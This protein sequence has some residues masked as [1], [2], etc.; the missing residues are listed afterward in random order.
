MKALVVYVGRKSKVNFDYGLTH[1]IWGFKP[2][3]KPEPEIAAGDWIIFG[4]GFS[5]GSPRTTEAAWFGHSIDELATARVSKP[6]VHEST[7]EW[8]DEK[9]KGVVEYSERLRFDRIQ[10]HTGP[11]HLVDPRL[12]RSVAQ[13]LRLSAISNSG[14]V[15]ELDRAP[16]TEVQRV[17]DHPN[18][19]IVEPPSTP[20]IEQRAAPD[21]LLE[22]E[23]FIRSRGF[24][25]DTAVLKR[26]YAS[27]RAKPFVIL[28][29]NSG[30][31]KSRLARLFAEAIGASTE[32]GRFQMI[33][34]R[35]DWNDSSDLL[36][37]FDLNGDYRPGQLIATLLRANGRRDKP[38]FV[39]LD[40]MNL[41]RVEH[42]FSDF[43]SIIESRRPENG[44]VASDPVLKDEHIRKMR[45]DSLSTD[46]VA[47]VEAMQRSPRSIGLPP[48]LYFV[49]TVNMDETTQPFS[50]KVL[51]R[52]N[53]L[54]FNDIDL[55][56][57]LADDEPGTPVPS[58]DLD[59]EFLSSQF[60]CLN[61]VR[62][63][64]R[65]TA[66]SVASFLEKL[67]SSL[68]LAGFEVG[69]RIRDE[70]IAFTIYAL[71]AGMNQKEAEENIVLQKVLPRVQGSSPRI[72]TALIAL[73]KQLA[74][75]EEFPEKDAADFTD[76]LAKFRGR[77]DISPV[78]RKIAGML[79]IFR[80]EG[81]TSF[82]LA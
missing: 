81:F 46:V 73:M 6:F 47:M 80:E 56:E 35:P 9:H 3:R 37:Y 45:R 15:V 67:N 42:Y 44:A 18:T 27:L 50:R 59:S 13:A 68:S 14:C 28:A 2:N 36:G 20:R 69:Y 34:V 11:I 62:G 64:H 61:D 30:T 49:G 58:L 23:N 79:L 33:P 54:E 76:R 41:A 16:F 66:G 5:G 71:G 25:F 60:T 51:D 43:L 75:S 40:E 38:F 77:A 31:G 82:W 10:K 26:Y 29:G 74:G 1:G 63:A 52:A 39:C 4:R 53:T 12:A 22:V 7:L 78:L 57:G 8:P 70:A 65:D 24:N 21:I 48:N 32:N 55:E 72:E 19:A 17:Q